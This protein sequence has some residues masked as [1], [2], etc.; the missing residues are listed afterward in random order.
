MAMNKQRR[1]SNINNIVTYDTLGNVT[2]PANLTIDG[3]TAAG[4]V[5]SDANGLL[6]VDTGAYL[7]IPSQT[8]NSGKFLTTNG[9]TLSWG[10]IDLSGYVPTSR[11]LTIN[12]TSYDLSANRSWTVADTNI[13][14]SDGTLTGNRMVTMGNFTL[15]FEKDLLVAGLTIGRG[16]LNIV[17]NTA[18]GFE[19]LLN[20]NNAS[21]TNNTAVGY[22]AMHL[23]QSGS[24]NTAVGVSALRIST[25]G[26]T[27]TAIGVSSLTF[28][29]SGSFNT[30]V[31]TNAGWNITDGTYNTTI[32]VQAG[33]GITS[34]S[35]NT[36]LGARV[37]GL[38]STLSNNIILADGQGNIRIRAFDT[39]NVAIGSNTDAGYKLD[40]QGTG[41]FTGQLQIG[42]TGTW[43]TYINSRTSLSG[44]LLRANYGVGNQMDL[45]FDLNGFLNMTG[46][47]FSAPTILAKTLLQTDGQLTIYG[48]QKPLY[49]VNVTDQYIMGLSGNTFVLRAASSSVASG[50]S[51]AFTAFVNGNISFN[52][53]TDYAS[54]QVA[55]DSTT[56]G[57]LPPRMTSTQR[58]AISSPAAGL[59]VYQTDSTEGLYQYLSTGWSAVSGGG[60]TNIYNSDGTLTG[61]RT[62][63]LGVNKL[64]FSGNAST[65]LFTV[66]NT[67]NNNVAVFKS[68]EP[69]ITV[70]AIGASN[71]ASIFLKPSTSAQNGTIQNRTGGGLE[72]YTGATPSL[73]MTIGSNLNVGIGASPNSINSL[74]IATANQWSGAFLGNMGGARTPSASNGIFL[75]W[76]YTGGSGEANFVWGNGTGSFPYLVFSTWNGSTKTDR[77]EFQDNGRVVF[78]QY[79]STSSFT[80]TAVGYLAFDSSGNVITVTPPSGTLSDGD[81]GDITV[82]GGGATWTIDNS[83]IGISKLSA[84]GT[85]SSSTYLRGDNTWATIPTT[86]S[87]TYTPTLT[88]IF[89]CTSLTLE[90]ATYIRVDNIVTVSI[91]VNLTVSSTTAKTE[92]YF[93]L[94]ISTSVNP[95]Y[96][97][98][99]GTII[100]SGSVANSV[101]VYIAS[102]DTTRAGLTCKA[103]NT[104]CS[105]NVIFQYRIN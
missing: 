6:S 105:V 16:S 69:Y 84:T 46:A 43:E 66:E 97:C 76:N 21:F 67:G 60:G 31:G 19:V 71:S 99:T 92:F 74:E 24:N 95:Q 80:G 86:V 3:L 9:S 79:T 44:I 101:A 22:R 61:D 11:T 52:S 28:L 4:F 34:G 82:S 18:I 12:G 55:I 51:L 23:H 38:S 32:G 90:G 42:N 81:K 91:G 39:G 104:T 27:N 93:S 53:S 47:K 5:K 70:E 102:G 54:A 96:Y 29:T 88:N 17:G 87:N 68:A 2:L 48:N 62:V 36:I 100:D 94:P 103:P 30:A 56:K 58:T 15:S 78:K 33:L 98:G 8:G 13:Y 59:I 41:R 57:F 64:T 25:T 65:S 26:F 77:V 20:L 49:F 85:A 1:T 72:F 63:S 37:S 40:V 50:G 35:N 14:N 10:T 45:T 73:A 75:G 89:N 83:T 7:P